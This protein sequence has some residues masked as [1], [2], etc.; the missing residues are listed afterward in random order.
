MSGVLGT[1]EPANVWQ[2]FEEI[3]QIPRP[4][5]REGKI[6]HW[7][8]Q[9]AEDHQ[10][11]CKEDDVGNLL[12]R[13]EATP[14]C[15]AYPTL[16]L[17][18]HMD[19]VC[20]RTADAE[21]DPACEP[22]SLTIVD[23]YVTAEGTSLGADNGIGVAYGMAALLADHHGPLEVV[24][25]VDEETGMTGAF[26]MKRGF[27]SGK[28]LLNLDGEI[29]GTIIIGS[30]GGGTTYYT[31]PRKLK[32]KTGRTGITIAVK[33]LRGGHSGV[34][35][36]PPRLS[37]IKT[38]VE[39]VDLLKEHMTI[40]I[41]SIDGGTVHNAIPRCAACTIIV[42]Q[43]KKDEAVTILKKWR[44][45]AFQKDEPE[46]KIDISTID[47]T[48]AL[49][50][51]DD[52]L[53]L[54]REIPYGAL[55]FNEEIDRSV[56][57]SNNLAVVTTGEETVEIIASSRS[58]VK[59]ELDDLQENLRSLGE[60]H[61]AMVTQGSG[62]PGWEPDHSSPFL[63]LVKQSYETV[64]NKEVSLEATHGGLECGVLLQLDPDLQAA[65]IGPNI[66]DVHSPRERVQIKSV[67]MLWHV[68]TTIIANMDDLR[69][70]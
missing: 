5:K 1:L 66:T 4:S 29:E 53:A 21:C 23:G 2:L 35:I 9:W 10:I 27:F 64:L 56:Q 41:S 68:V 47:E 58:S 63:A 37:A 16:V 59:Q 31:F 25:T 32:E 50:C 52:L 17:Q 22:L 51:S 67:E 33:G 13:A 36:Y 42:S 3:T 24:L 70:K 57:T 61:G 45:S 60:M 14:G 11:L 18:A 69:E 34:D 15:E 62:Y 28:Y 30:A 39:G 65:S 55:S 38:L 48:R 49:S 40:F 26:E 20:Q 44:E 12:L 54:L 8:T 6:R 19:M 7:I 43:E 46:M